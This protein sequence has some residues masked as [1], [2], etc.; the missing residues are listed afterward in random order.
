MIMNR[1]TALLNSIRP[2]N[3][4]AFIMFAAILP[5]VNKFKL[6]SGYIRGLNFALEKFCAKTD[7]TCVFI[8]AYQPFMSK[9]VK[10]EPNRALFSQSDGLHLE[11]PGLDK[12]E[13]IIQQAFST[14]YLLD[15]VTCDLNVN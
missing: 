12:L 11:G 9:L 6:L 4:T 3:K 14:E 10:N 1:Y 7:G 5:R 13:E 8:P 15:R 2:R